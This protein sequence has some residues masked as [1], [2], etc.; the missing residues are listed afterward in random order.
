MRPRGETQREKGSP[1]GRRGALVLGLTVLALGLAGPAANAQPIARRVPP[2]PAPQAAATGPRLPISLADAVFIGLRDNRTVKSA[3]LARVAEK[4]DLFV[5]RSRFQPVGLI[6]ARADRARQDGETRSSLQLTPTAAWLIP[7]GAQFQFAWSRLDLRGPGTSQGTDTAVLSVSQPLLRGAGL[8]VNTA[9]VTLANLQERINRL[10]LKSTVSNTVAS[11]IGAYRVLLQAQEQLALARQSLERSRSQLQTNQA[12]I[13]AGRMAAAELVQ[14]EADIANQQVALLAAEQQ[15]NSAQLALLGLLAMDLHTDIVAGDALTPR[16]EVVDLDLAIAVA[17][18]NRPDYLAQ[19]HGLEQ[20]RQT[21]I[22]ARNDQLWDLSVGASL[23]RQ[24]QH[25]GGGVAIDPITGAP[26]PAANLPGGS[27]GSVGVQLRIPLGDHSIRQGEVRAST[28]VKIQEVQLED[29]RQRVEAEVRDAV[30]GVELAW[31]RLE[32][33]RLARDLAART[34][35][36]QR[37]KLQVGRASNFEVLSFEANLRAAD[38]QAL[39]AEIGYLNA[40]T[41]LDLQLGTTLDTWK[42]SLND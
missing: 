11:I 20:A 33:A 5:A 3:Y 42:I 31:R 2:P 40:L 14:T 1:A 21:L 41:G 17:L 4:Y 9:P 27:S 39:T 29:Q 38:T 37:E 15:R 16:H 22:V 25:G 19:K 7:T 26:V 18:D 36:L 6:D 13:D 12:L 24:T 35:N 32:A 23:Q 30:Q 34:L 10:A 8:A 28:A